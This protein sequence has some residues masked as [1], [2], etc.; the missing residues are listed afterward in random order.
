MGLQG[1]V[2]AG[3]CAVIAL[4]SQISAAPSWRSSMPS[5]KFSLPTAAQQNGSTLSPGQGTAAGQASISSA[6]HLWSSRLYEALPSLV[7]EHK[8]HKNLWPLG[9]RDFL[10]FGIATLGLFIAAGGG[11][12]GGAI[13]VPVYLIVLG[14]HWQRKTNCNV[15]KVHSGFNTAGS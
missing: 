8:L 1:T 4:S 3:F 14:E 15:S 12:G 7:V 10:G 13:L 5:A 9:T 2:L 11:I 6:V